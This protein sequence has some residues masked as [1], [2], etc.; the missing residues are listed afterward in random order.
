VQQKQCPLYLAGINEA[1]TRYT[2]WKGDRLETTIRFYVV[3][4]TGRESKG[5]ELI[6][7]IRL[8][9]YDNVRAGLG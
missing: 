9:V 2:S 3:Q 4:E 1:G 8:N 7:T 6:T 5:G